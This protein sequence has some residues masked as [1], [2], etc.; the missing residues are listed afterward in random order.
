[1]GQPVSIDP[2]RALDVIARGTKKIEAGFSGLFGVVENIYHGGSPT[3]LSGSGRFHGVGDQAV[4]D[5]SRR[6][7]HVE[8][9]TYFFGALGISPHNVG[10]FLGV[11]VGRTAVNHFLLYPVEFR[12]F[13]KDGFA[14]EGDQQIGGIPQS[15]VGGDA[16]KTVGPTTFKAKGKF[17]QWSWF[18]LVFVGLDEANEGLF[19]GFCDEV[20]FGFALLLLQDVER[21]AECGRQLIERLL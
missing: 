5:V 4:F 3:L 11:G 9:G 12:E 14:A 2:G 18:T 6:R 21:L 13:G 19:N 15:R 10:E 1:M 8:A 20:A 7:I 17:A 16:G